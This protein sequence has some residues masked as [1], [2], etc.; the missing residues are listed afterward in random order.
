MAGTMGERPRAMATVRQ[1]ADDERAGDDPQHHAVLEEVVDRE[2]PQQERA[3]HRQAEE[4]LL[5]VRLDEARAELAHGLVHRIRRRPRWP[6][7]F[8]LPHDE[9]SL[10]LPAL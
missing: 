4:D 7:V 3:R 8:G 5:A 9:P 1:Q 2:G 10:L 6:P